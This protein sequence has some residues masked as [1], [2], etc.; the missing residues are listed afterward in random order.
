LARLCQRWRLM[1]EDLTRRLNQAFR[2][3]LS[4]G[5][6]TEADVDAGL[7][8][9]RLALLEADV[10]YKVARDFIAGVRTEAVGEAVLKSVTPGQQVVKIVHDHLVELLGGENEGISPAAEPPT[11]VMTLGL[12]GSG[13]TT[14]AAKLAVL[15]RKQG[16]Q[17]LLVGADVHRPAAKDQL[18][19]LAR[20]TD[21]PYFSTSGAAEEIAVAALP[22]AQ[23]LGCDVVLIDTA[24]RLQ[25]DD[26]MMQEA[27]RIRERVLVHESLLVLDAMTGQEAVNVGTEFARQVGVDGI[28][29]TKM[30]GDARGGAAL[31]IKSVTGLPVMYVGTGE[32]LSDLEVFHADRV[33]SRILGMGDVVSLVERARETLDQDVAEETARQLA[34][35]RFTLDDFVTQMRQ[36]RKLGP[37]ESI[38]GMLPAGGQLKDIAG[39]MP[40]EKDLSHVEAIIL[41][42]TRAEREHPA[43]LDGRRK[44]RIAQGSG[45]TVEEVNQL[46]KGFA[47]MQQLMKQM[48][49]G[50]LPRIPGMP[51][52]PSIRQ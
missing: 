30:D 48:G 37:I 16:R 34:K 41:S 39:A 14:T 17:P 18:A 3:M 22:E 15:L 26:E 13:K 43:L 44:R 49:R 9:V 38:I 20:A 40:S 1:F 25:L 7:R 32:K 23:R 24:G 19:V 50:K 52:L 2:G 21:I 31:S 45:R 35:G 10:N 28:V 33:A 51:A 36:V 12:Q 42:M 11:V 4:R 29:M 46:L 6:L 8:E 5:V 47:Q 27:K